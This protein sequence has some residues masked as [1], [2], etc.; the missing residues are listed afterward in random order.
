MRSLLNRCGTAL[1]VSVYSLSLLGCAPQ[2]P[3]PREESPKPLPAEKPVQKP[4]AQTPQEDPAVMEKIEKGV[5]LEEELLTL[6]L[7]EPNQ[8]QGLLMR[9]RIRSRA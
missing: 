4:S 3:I 6:L 5:I 1:I 2:P 7:R 9:S 8:R